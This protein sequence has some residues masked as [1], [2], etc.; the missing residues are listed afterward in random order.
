MCIYLIG[1]MGSGKTTLGQALAKE[2]GWSFLDLDDRIEELA[3]KSIPSIFREESEKAFRILEQ[4]AL[5]STG[6]LS[7]AVIATG[8]G[9]PCHFDNF[10]WIKTH[11]IS[12]YLKA[13]P[14]LLTQ[15][16]MAQ[17][18]HRPLLDNLSEEEL[19][20]YIHK[21]LEQRARYYQQADIQFEQQ[22]DNAEA[23]AR[24]L[25]THFEEITGH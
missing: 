18:K 25:A 24:E 23:L 1:F 10:D 16:L 19:S 11:G 2:M 3:G 8:G 15:R 13:S 12:V 22:Q 9:T 14:T 4:Q 21:M 17:Q 20:A 6:E 7:N 5:H